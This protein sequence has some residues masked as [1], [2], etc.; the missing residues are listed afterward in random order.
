LTFAY[1]TSLIS[2]TI[3]SSVTSINWGAFQDCTSL[4]SVTFEGTISSS[5]FT[6]KYQG[7][8]TTI[9]DTFPGDLCDKFYAND[10]TNGTPGTYTR[11]NGSSTTWT[12]MN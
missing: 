10:P 9:Y 11:P 6:A 1:C 7:A 12:K 4:T 5:K 2:V 8:S 3:P